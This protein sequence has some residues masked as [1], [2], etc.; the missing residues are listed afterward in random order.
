M[1]LLYF[2]SKMPNFGDDLNPV[3]WPV[4]RPDLF[5]SSDGRG[6]VGIGSIIGFNFDEAFKLTVFSSGTGYEAINKWSHREVNYVCVRGPLSARFLGLDAG[7]ALTDGAIVIPHVE[8]FPKKALGG[9]NPLI[10]PHWESLLEPGWEDVARLTGFDLLDPRCDP[11]VAAQTIASASIVLTESLHGAIVA[12]LYGIPWSA[13]ITSKNISV[14]K[15]LDWLMSL[16]R[17]FTATNIP[18]PN[19]RLLEKHGRRNETYGQPVTFDIEAALND[20]RLKAASGSPGKISAA[21]RL[22]ALAKSTGL[23]SLRY[24]CSPERTAEYLTRMVSN[25][26]DP[27]PQAITESKADEMLSRLNAIKA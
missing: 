26:G 3:V 17:S 23:L 27:T 20:P 15:W 7:I 1:E 22:R 4:L 11:Y 6:F 18:P 24:N 13:F 10:I 21:A 8:G 14:P 5:E 9:G 25:I 19:P 16:N 12:D 2:K